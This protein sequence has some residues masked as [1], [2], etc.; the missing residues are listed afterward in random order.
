MSGPRHDAADGELSGVEIHGEG[1]KR[2]TQGTGIDDREAGGRCPHAGAVGVAD[3][4]EA[5]GG[6]VRGGDRGG[7]GGRLAPSA[8]DAQGTLRRPKVIG[9]DLER[10]F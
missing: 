9:G 10:V 3:E 8:E 5:S 2:A 1:P 7:A 6:S 4:H